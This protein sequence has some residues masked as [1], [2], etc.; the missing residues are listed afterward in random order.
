MESRGFRQ[1]K[2]MRTKDQRE[3]QDLDREAGK[4][5]ANACGAGVEH[6]KGGHHDAPSRQK[7]KESRQPHVELLKKGR[8]MRLSEPAFISQAGRLRRQKGRSEAHP[9]T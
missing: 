5:K 1:G 3:A 8:K 6:G 2:P 9:K 7:Q 4:H